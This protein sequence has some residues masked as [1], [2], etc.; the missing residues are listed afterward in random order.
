M[1]PIKTYIRTQ[2]DRTPPDGDFDRH[3]ALWDS[4]YKGNDA[5]FHT[6]TANNG[7]NVTA[8]PMFRLQMAKKVAE[9]WAN[10][11][12]NERTRFLTADPSAQTFLD[13][14]L[15][16]NDFCAN[17]NR[18]T[19]KTFALGT[20]AVVVGLDR[21][22][23][24][25][26]NTLL[27]DRRTRIRTDF[28]T[29]RNIIPLS[30]EQ[31]RITEAAFVCRMNRGGQ[32]VAYLQLHLLESDG[33]VIQSRCLSEETWQEIPLPQGILPLVRTKS[34]LPWFAIFKPNLVNNV[35]ADSPMGISVYANAIDSLKGLDLCLDSFNM[36][37]YLGKKMVFL[38]R[39]LLTS[40]QDGQLYAPQDINRQLFMYLG[41]KALDGD[42][43]PR[44]FNPQLRVGDHVAAIAAHLNYLSVQCGF[45]ERFYRFDADGPVT[46]TQIISENS[47]LFRSVRKHELALEQPLK[48]LMRLILRLGR[49]I[50]G[51]TYDT[52]TP[53]TVQ[54]DDSIIEDKPSEQ[55]RDLE[56]VRQNILRPHEYRMKHFGETEAVAKEALGQP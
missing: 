28:V 7:V 36:E 4:W 26:D 31:D 22:A 47:T 16:E 27:P 38:R 39:D 2:F 43:L 32:R 49:D 33:Y 8:R 34:T 40:D 3:V 52:E 20:G 19:E 12:L 23:V 18:L 44:E 51:L 21:A 37:F 46:A 1:D 29:A 11:L 42:M 13:K 10:L 50:S 45:G 54:F 14:T 25:K 15:E 48:Q 30:W 9:D 55:A 17:I 5:A 6:V 41:D 56:L 24:A 35:A 53:L